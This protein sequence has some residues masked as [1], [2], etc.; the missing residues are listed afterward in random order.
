MRA[1][2]RLSDNALVRESLDI[3]FCESHI[4][5]IT[6]ALLSNTAVL[7]VAITITWHLLKYDR[8]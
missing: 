4:R 1:L 6:E 8:V 3:D 2:H 5:N 7:V